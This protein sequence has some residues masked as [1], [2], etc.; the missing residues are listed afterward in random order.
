VTGQLLLSDNHLIAKFDYDPELVAAIKHISG[1]KWDRT[2]RVWK[3]PIEQLTQASQFATTHNWWIEP[4]LTAL[5]PPAATAPPQLTMDDNNVYINF[6]YDPVKVRA[7]KKIPGVTWDKKTKAWKAPM[8]SL[9]EAAD[10]AQQFGIPV[11][12]SASG[13][14]AQITE[15][16]HDLIRKSKDIDADLRV[17]DIPLLAYQRAGVRYAIEARRT[18]IADDM[19]LGKTVTSIAAIE[20]ASGAADTYPVVVVCPPTLV[21]NWKKEYERWLPEKKVVTVKNRKDFPESGYDV[22]VVGYS[23]IKAWENQLKN[24]KSYIFDESHYL[25]SPDAQRTKAAL[26]IAKTAPSDGMVLCLTG[27]P[28]TNKPAEYAPQ[29]EL[30]GRIGDFGGRWGFYRRYCNAF[31]DRFGQWNLDGHSNLDELN[32][33]LRGTC[34]IRRTKEQ[35]LS[36][37]PPVRHHRLIAEGT[38][39][40]VREYEKA[41]KDVVN[42]LMERAKE[43]AAE[44]GE[45]PRSAAVR[46][47]I[48]AEA[49]IHLVKIGVLRKLAARAKMPAVIEFVDSHIAEGRKLVIAAHHREIVDELASKYGNLKI[50]GRMSVDEVEAAKTRFQELPAADAPV[51]V[52]SIQAAKTGH[53]LTAAQDVLFVEL[54]WTWADIE[55]TYS[56]CHRLG[57][58]GS[59]TSTYLLC[60]GTIDEDIYDLV[61]QKRKLVHTAV[62]GG[63]LLL[64]GTGM[65]VLNGFLGSLFD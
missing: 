4:E 3:I 18:F 17:G 24:H 61:D 46:A 5:N 1:A 44:T 19:G 6:A 2:Q 36:E 23:N 59:V 28:V 42:Y 49:N 43:I 64:G 20:L 27:T 63:D 62:Q 50:Q 22:L 39:N 38:V 51:M 9:A 54:P 34:Y 25:K 33:R 58:A 11:D 8:A 16:R 15:K 56:R 32:D 40:G 26:K 60:E 13:A 52:L 41:R 31:I 65:D 12:E 47:K 48:K 35:V 45:S 21:L 55:Q 7:V 30:L 57:Q 29:L 10:W 53:T 14:I 37:L